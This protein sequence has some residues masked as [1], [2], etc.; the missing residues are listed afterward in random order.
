MKH[1]HADAC[2]IR[3]SCSAVKQCDVVV[4]TLK[5]L[6]PRRT[7]QLWAT[8]QEASQGGETVMVSDV[9]SRQEEIGTG[10]GMV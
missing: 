9:R 6:L 10:D 1:L 7:G 4:T 2:R 5:R 3:F 8:G